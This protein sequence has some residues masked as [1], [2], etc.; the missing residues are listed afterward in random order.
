MKPAAELSALS[1]GLRSYSLSTRS[2]V[3]RTLAIPSTESSSPG[4][5]TLRRESGQ[6]H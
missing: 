1:A 3:L 6:G 2:A 5:T 4:A